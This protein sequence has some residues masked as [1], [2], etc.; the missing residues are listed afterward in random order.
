[1]KHKNN[2]P[3]EKNKK[4]MIIDLFGKISPKRAASEKLQFQVVQYITNKAVK[5]YELT[6][7]DMG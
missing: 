6:L 7:Q 2:I 4:K 5:M 3:Q 1:M